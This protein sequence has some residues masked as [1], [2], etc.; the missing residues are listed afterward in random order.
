[1]LRD[2]RHDRADDRCDRDAPGIAGTRLTQA[3]DEHV[4]IG[5]SD[6][7]WVHTALCHEYAEEFGSRAGNPE[8]FPG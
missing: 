5:F 1:M 2:D 7:E 4:P 8:D 6:E 3:D